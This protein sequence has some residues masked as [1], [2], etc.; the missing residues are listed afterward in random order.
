MRHYGFHVLSGLAR[1]VAG[2]SRSAIRLS[3]VLGLL[4][5]LSNAHASFLYP[6]IPSEP[7]LSAKLTVNIGGLYGNRIF[8]REEENS[9]VLL[10]LGFSPLDLSSA[11][12]GTSSFL[13][14]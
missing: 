1:I 13:H 10:A 9:A 8:F 14:P 3:L 11:R 6:P 12:C 2:V 5:M 7:I 4:S